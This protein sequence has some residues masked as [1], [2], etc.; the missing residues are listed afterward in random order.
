[1]SYSDKTHPAEVSVQ[2]V[3]SNLSSMNAV[4]TKRVDMLETELARLRMQRYVSNNRPD[5][6]QRSFA[7]PSWSS[8]SPWR[9]RFYNNEFRPNFSPNS[10]GAEYSGRAFNN[11]RPRFFPGSIDSAQ[12][13][14]RYGRDAL[15]CQSPC[16]WR[17][18]SLT[19]NADWSINVNVNVG[20][21]VLVELFL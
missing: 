14:S 1:M 13:T 15:S 20:D 3:N 17:R 21:G 4:L 5:T 12:R 18:N 10:R 16:D 6:N 9:N 11:E 8:Q 19:K 7:R 2:N